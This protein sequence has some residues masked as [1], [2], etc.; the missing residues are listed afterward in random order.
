M[1]SFFGLKV[2]RCGVRGNLWDLFCQHWWLVLLELHVQSNKTQQMKKTNSCITC[3]KQQM[4]AVQCTAEHDCRSYFK[5]ESQRVL[6]TNHLWALS[7]NS[8]MKEKHDNC[9]VTQGWKSHPGRGVQC[10]VPCLLEFWS[11]E[12]AALDR[13]SIEL[14]CVHWGRRDWDWEVSFTD[15]P[16]VMSMLFTFMFGFSP[17]RRR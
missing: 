10:D 8:L 2:R 9:N 7:K 4:Q 14:G 17:A 16:P 1:W 6:S 11:S 5:N 12:E 13:L 15:K 3:R